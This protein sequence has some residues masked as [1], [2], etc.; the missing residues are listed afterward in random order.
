MDQIISFW[1]DNSSNII[2]SFVIGFIFFVLGPI[3]LWFSSRK[4]RQ[5]R[6]KKAK[7]LLIDLIEGMIVS[8]EE[9]TLEK[10][11]KMYRAIEREVDVSIDSHYD[12]ERLFEDVML[13]FQ[14]SKHLD[15]EQKNAYAK[16]LSELIVLVDG[17]TKE[18]E[19]S[20]IPKSYEKLFRELSHGIDH[21]DKDAITESIEQLKRR[22]LRL[23]DFNDPILNIFKI[24]IRL[25]RD[26]P[27]VFMMVLIITVLIYGL[28]LQQLGVINIIAKP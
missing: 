2:I 10:L 25:L 19:T 22:I 9:I 6:I 11:K 5:E 8:G 28:V 20:D 18:K 26:K 12:L 3:G 15:S 17:K 1:N 23:N 7:D 14:R 16:Q 24:Y 21:N 13:R 4:V 27:A